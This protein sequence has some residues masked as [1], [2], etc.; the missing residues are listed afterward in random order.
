MESGK[1]T[2]SIQLHG[3]YSKKFCD[4]ISSKLFYRK[5]TFKNA[6]I[7][8]L[9][10]AL[11][12]TRIENKYVVVS[13]HENHFNYQQFQLRVL[14]IIRGRREMVL[15]DTTSS[16]RPYVILKKAMQFNED[17]PALHREDVQSHLLNFLLL[18][19]TTGCS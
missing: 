11:K 4:S 15:L 18:D 2:S 16:C 8:R 9:A 10:V 19:F 5:K 6:Q 13:F 7:R 14:R 12:K 17:F 3:R 1:R